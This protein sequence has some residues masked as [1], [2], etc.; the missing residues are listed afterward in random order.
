MGALSAFVFL[1]VDHLA[2]AVVP[3]VRAWAEGGALAPFWQDVLRVAHRSPPAESDRAVL[4][5][6]FEDPRSPRLPGGLVVPKAPLEEPTRDAIE[7]AV[8]CSARGEGIAWRN[9]R[10]L[11]ID[12]EAALPEL[13]AGLFDAVLARRPAPTELGALLLSLD[14][15]ALTLARADGGFG[16]G[17][18]GWLDANE[19]AK[20][21]RRLATEVPCARADHPISLLDELHDGDAPRLEDATR[22]LV[23]LQRT[24]TL[25]AR[26]GLGLLHGRDLALSPWGE[27]ERGVFRRR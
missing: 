15:G 2:E 20:L 24:A 11:T 5:A 8:L 25:A 3:S 6:A 1:D 9:A 26:D 21:A 14:Q 13:L 7:L 16:E 4:A 10:S 18:R 22:T 17:L 27:W 12:G 19:T 23:L